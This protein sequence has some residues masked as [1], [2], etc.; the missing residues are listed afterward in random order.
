[1][2]RNPFATLIAAALG[3]A[4]SIPATAGGTGFSGRV[5]FDFTHLDQTDSATDTGESGFGLDVKRIYLGF[6]HAFN[7]TWSANLILDSQYL[8]D[9]GVDALFVKKAY[10]QGRFSD[11]AV[12]RAGAADMVWVPFVE[13]Y[14]GY[15]YIE[16]T[17]VDRLKFGASTDWGLH[18][19]GEVGESGAFNYAVSAVNGAGYKEPD[20]SG[21]VDFEARVG[22]AP[23]AGMMVAV[24]GYS[25]KLGGERGAADT[26][27]TATRADALIAYRTDSVRIGAEYFR[28]S[29]WRN[30]ATPESD[31]ADGWSAWA[32]RQITH[33]IAVFARYDRASPSRDLD[34]AARDTYYNAGVEYQVAEGFKLAAVYKHTERERTAGAAPSLRTADLRTDEIGAWGELRF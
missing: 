17:L 34:P 32:S 30:V 10:L 16:N 13:S 24:G 25:G 26:F 27:H 15:R 23:L 5:Y 6:E 7:E 19:G 3:L 12:L 4:V 18:L 33:D 9:D 22:F 28:A 31:R 8:R 11:A 21:A 1:M 29:N 14:Y 20:R 2:H